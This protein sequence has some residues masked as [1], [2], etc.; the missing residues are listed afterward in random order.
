VKPRYL[1]LLSTAVLVAGPARAQLSLTNGQH[2]LDISGLVT[3]FYNQ[4]FY[5][6]GEDNFKKNR[7]GLRDA[8]LNL[9]GRI[10]TRYE[11]RLQV[12]FADIASTTP[13]PENP[14]ILDA[15]FTYKI[16]RG[17][18][19][20]VGFGKV[21]YSRASL[22]PFTYSPYF[23]RAEL[24][25]GGIFGR[26]DMGVTLRRSLWQQR[27]NLAA[28]AY[29]GLAESSLSTGDND[30][31]G[32]PEIVGRADLAWPARYRYRDIDVDHVPIPMLAIGLNARYADKAQTTGADYQ[33][34]TIDGRRTAAGFDVSAQWQGVSAQFEAHRLRAEPRDLTRLYGQ[35]TSYFQAGGYV[36]QLNYYFKPARL[37]L[38]GRY[39]NWNLNDLAPGQNRR[40]SAAVA[41]RLD[42]WN[43]VIKAQWQHALEE[44]PGLGDINWTEQVRVGWQ[45]VLQ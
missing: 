18:D 26:R 35:P 16:P 2:T 12:D 44:E 1:L 42:G 41:W 11:Y 6:P 22:V 17:V 4:R 36:A 3:G 15:N 40:I 9:E 37:I 10:G 45:L 29:T 24:V 43:S 21:P 30:R 7:F 31:R 14:P 34:T 5:K 8:Q 28:G 27:I 32:N 13:D 33:L 25:R 19:V 20:T 39:E 38:S 23:Q